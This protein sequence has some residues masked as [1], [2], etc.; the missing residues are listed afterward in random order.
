MNQVSANSTSHSSI[1]NR[2]TIRQKLWY[3]ERLDKVFVDRLWAQPDLLISEGTMLKDG[4]RSTVVRHD[5]KDRSYTIKRY[6]AMG[7]GHTITHGVLRTRA[8]W[9]WINGRRVIASGLN[10]PRPLACLEIRLGPLRG[11]SFFVSDY[12]EGEILL[13]LVR[14]GGLDRARLESLATVMGEIWKTLGQKGLSHG[15]M[16]ATNFIAMDDNSLWLLD[17]DGMRQP[18]VRPWFKRQRAKDRARFMKNW[19]GLAACEDVFLACVDTA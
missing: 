1:Q 11:R 6:K 3:D 16:K 5:A 18:L 13:D 10:T 19:R 17:L 9:S 15:D 2:S 4:D 14:D 12:I 7:L 8:S